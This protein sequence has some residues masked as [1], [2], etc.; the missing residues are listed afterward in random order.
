MRLLLALLLNLLALLPVAA[1]DG[2]MRRYFKDWLGAC[3]TDGYC[4]A[5][6]Y[7]NPNPGDGRVA[8]YWF[9]VGRHAEET[10]WELSFTPIKVMANP[11]MPFTLLVDGKGETFIGPTEIA[12]FGSINDFFLLGSKAQSVMDQLM[13]GRRLDVTFTDDTGTTGKASFSLNG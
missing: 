1:Q 8:D 11:A 10:Y 5:I 9:R 6:A 3:R 13:P 4:S 2:E 7:V 12:P